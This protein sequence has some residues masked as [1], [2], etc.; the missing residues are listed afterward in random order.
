ML[1]VA[2]AAGT[3]GEVGV[4]GAG[5]TCGTA[6]E[7]DFGGKSG[8]V[9]AVGGVPVSGGAE[10][11]GGWGVSVGGGGVFEMLGIGAVT[12]VDQAG[13]AEE[14]GAGTN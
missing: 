11:L 6:W 3:G 2:L 9:F 8:V 1:A 14:T 5:V 10:G 4:A 13:G 7:G 12:A